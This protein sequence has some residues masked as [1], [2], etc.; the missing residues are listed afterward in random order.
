MESLQRVIKISHKNM[1]NQHKYDKYLTSALGVFRANFEGAVV[2]SARLVHVQQIG[3]MMAGSSNLIIST[4]ITF[5]CLRTHVEMRESGFGDV[6]LSSKSTVSSA[7][8]LGACPAP[9]RDV[10]ISLLLEEQ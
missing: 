2:Q 10:Y 6:V 8:A 9:S 4:S 7:T 5:C 1:Q 3:F